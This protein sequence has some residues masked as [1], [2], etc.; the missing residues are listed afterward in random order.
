MIKILITVLVY[1]FVGW[2]FCNIDPGETYSWF[3]G[4][5]HGIFFIPNL[6][7]SI[8][9]DAL[10]KAQS[11]TDAY[12]VFWWISVIFSITGGAFTGLFRR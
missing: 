7:R 4:I 1:C 12:N 10:F 2:L 8:F 3:S 11:Y 9:T 6:L 5:W